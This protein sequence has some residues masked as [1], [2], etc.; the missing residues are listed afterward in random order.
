V[1]LCEDCHEI[2]KN[3]D[4]KKMFADLCVNNST[5]IALGFLIKK[6]IPQHVNKP[7]ATEQ[8]IWSFMYD[9]LSEDFR[10]GKGHEEFKEFTGLYIKQ[11]N[12]K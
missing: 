11:K 1:T 7:H 4:I 10:E 3:I 2:Q 5:V 6:I 9:Q 12:G 8:A